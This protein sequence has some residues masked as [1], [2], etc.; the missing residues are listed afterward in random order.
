MLIKDL[1]EFDLINR[2]AQLLPP[3][4][5]DVVVGVGDDVAVVDTGGD[6]YLL[7]T[8]DIQVENT[9]FLPSVSPHQLGRKAAAVNLSDIGAKGGEPLHFLVSLALR[10]ETSVRW[11]DEFYRGLG[12]E[13]SRHGA[14]IIGGNLSHTQGPQ[15]V[16]L[17]L[18]GKVKKDW[19]LLRKGARPG[20]KVLVTGQLGNA[21]GGLFLLTQ[22]SL[23]EKLTPEGAETLLT[24]L[25]TP[26]PRVRE[27]QTIAASHMATA[28][29]DISDGLAQ[30][31]LHICEASGVG[32]RIWA[33]KIPLSLALE[34]LAQLLSTTPWLL[35]LE[36]GEDYELCFTSPA[37]EAEE[38]AE[39]V[40]RA[41]GTPV[42][43]IGEVLPQKEGQWI[44][45]PQGKETPL[46]P[47]GWNHFRE[48][49][50]GS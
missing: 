5:R 6:H 30:D 22:E 37:G 9:H 15:V 38:L 10:A 26:T 29:L 49:A 33:E 21:K 18:T 41:T 35:A 43:I 36:G 11:V 46:S 45:T 42:T 27:G 3:C 23:R 20:D 24:A 13:A 50:D 47:R 8:C 31:L 16:D 19:L 1:G 48:V 25:L 39:E 2:I 7:L 34:A 14:D 32:V 44:V 40:E 4:S 12:E 28:M 17:F